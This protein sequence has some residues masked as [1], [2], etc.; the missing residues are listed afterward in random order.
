MNKKLVFL[1][2]AMALPEFFWGQW[3]A[4]LPS[5]IEALPQISAKQSV[6]HIKIPTLFY[7]FDHDPNPGI[8]IKYSL[9]D[10]QFQIDWLNQQFA[11]VA[12]LK[13][14]TSIEFQVATAQ[15]GKALPLPHASDFTFVEQAVDSSTFISGQGPQ[16]AGVFYIDRDPA[17]IIAL[18]DRYI[19]AM[20]GL[21]HQN[22]L[23][24]IIAQSAQHGT[25]GSYSTFI[26]GWS[27]YQSPY[28]HI[29]LLHDHLHT[30]KG[31]L[32]DG[33]VLVHEV[34]HYLGLA[35]VFEDGCIAPGDKISDT[36][37]YAGHNIQS[38]CEHNQQDECPSFKASYPSDRNN[39]MDYKGDFCRSEFTEGQV[40]AM[41][42]AC[43]QFLMPLIDPQNFNQ[44]SCIR[45]ISQLDRLEVFPGLAA[46]KMALR[47]ASSDLLVYPNPTQDQLNVQLGANHDAYRLLVKE[48]GGRLVFQ[49]NLPENTESSSISLKGL[50]KG[51]YILEL[52]SAN[53]HQ[54]IRFVKN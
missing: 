52:I 43:N 30:K 34:G 35:H 26:S 42:N 2:I 36:P 20:T 5:E 41:V 48:S 1:L 6:D 45:D 31:S 40:S 11:Q 15:A 46:K 13:P 23:V 9:H 51:Y 3:C 54:K 38:G 49:E 44:A 53:K 14:N 39:H 27:K 37:P 47:S 33:D 10:L 32:N 18:T 24:I 17:K 29:V 19:D 12:N 16:R 22:Y 4:T 7:I 8:Q 25:F 21:N 28:Q 50:D